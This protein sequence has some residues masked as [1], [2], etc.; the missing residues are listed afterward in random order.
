ME[1]IVLYVMNL[2]HTCR[3]N[4]LGR[5]SKMRSIINKKTAYQLTMGVKLFLA[6]RYKKYLLW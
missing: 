4:L 5:Q 1:N 2:A 3:C 6:I